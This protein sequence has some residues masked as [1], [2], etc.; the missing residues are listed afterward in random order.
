MDGVS[1]TYCYSI[2]IR[3]VRSPPGR[4]RRGT[5]DITVSA[6]ASASA[7]AITAS[8]VRCGGAE[9]LAPKRRNIAVKKGPRR[10]QIGQPSTAER[11]GKTALY[12]NGYTVTVRPRHSIHTAP[13]QSSWCEMLTLLTSGRKR[14]LLWDV[15][16]GPKEAGDV[17]GRRRRRRSGKS[18]RGCGE[19]RRHGRRMGRVVSD[20]GMT[21]FGVSYDA[22]CRAA[23]TC[24]NPVR[25]AHQRANRRRRCSPRRPNL[26]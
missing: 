9:A 11:Q 5:V 17:P 4:R 15:D 8:H 20:S 1:R 6:S 18:W 21:E 22:R 25:P 12:S 7:N 10:H 23:T 24:S 16:V 26:R 13:R 14:R 3:V 19:Y 2:S